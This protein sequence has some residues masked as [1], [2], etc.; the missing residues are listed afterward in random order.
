MSLCFFKSKRSCPS[1]IFAVNMVKGPFGLHQRQKYF[2]STLNLPND[3]KYRSLSHVTF[4]R[5]GWGMAQRKP[6]FLHENSPLLHSFGAKNLNF[7]GRLWLCLWGKYFLGKTG[8]QNR[9][10]GGWLHKN[11]DD[12][13]LLK[14]KNQAKI[15][16]LHSK[17]MVI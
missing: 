12:F 13:Y 15:G 10:H 6:L 2:N 9:Q 14:L 5:T 4:L 11:F 3:W 1:L 16:E 8:N 17:T 7:R